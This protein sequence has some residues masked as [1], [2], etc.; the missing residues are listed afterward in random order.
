MSIEL[1]Q[2]MGDIR[3]LL[4]ERI[5]ENNKAN[6]HEYKAITISIISM[7]I[8]SVVGVSIWGFAIYGAY[9]FFMND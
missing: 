3:C 1:D 9:K 6:T 7:I 5:M 2:H 8:A 4:K